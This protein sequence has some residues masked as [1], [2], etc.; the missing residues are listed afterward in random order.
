MGRRLMERV[1]PVLLGV[2]LGILLALGM[3][4]IMMA[5][6]HAGPR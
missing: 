6:T 1:D 5:S 3:T 2:V 4:A